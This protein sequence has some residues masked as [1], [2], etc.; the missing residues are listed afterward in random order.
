VQIYDSPPAGAGWEAPRR[1]AGFARVGLL[2]GDHAQ[3]RIAIDPRLLA[4]WDS[5]DP[6]WTRAAGAYTVSLGRSSRD[7]VRSATIALPARYLTPQW[8]P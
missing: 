2:P 6:G 4:V 7:L 8:K 3:V 1:L 5:A